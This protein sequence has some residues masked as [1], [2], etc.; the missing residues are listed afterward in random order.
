MRAFYRSS[1][2]VDG[3]NDFSTNSGHP[4]ST[5]ELAR[6]QLQFMHLG[7][8]S[9]AVSKAKSKAQQSDYPNADGV[10]FDG[11]TL[12]EDHFKSKQQSDP[13]NDKWIRLEFTS[14][15]FVSMPAGIVLRMGM[16]LE[17][18]RTFSALVAMKLPV[19]NKEALLAG[20][21]FAIGKDAE[22]YRSEYIKALAK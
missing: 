21:H 5:E 10:E 3:A 11:S 15:D 2:P 18:L 22:K 13:T 7:T 12:D 4:V 8:D 16:D 9:Q 1:P 6:L 20:K 14:G 19:G 17:V